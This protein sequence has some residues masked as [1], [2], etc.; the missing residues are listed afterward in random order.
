[1]A[2]P[3]SSADRE[4]SVADQF[5]PCPRFREVYQNKQ[6]THEEARIISSVRHLCPHA[7]YL[8]AFAPVRE[9]HYLRKA[10]LEYSNDSPEL[11][12]KGWQCRLMPKTSIGPSVKVCFCSPDGGVHTSKVTVLRKLGIIDKGVVFRN[13]VGDD[14]V[15]SRQPR[16]RKAPSENI[17]YVRPEKRN[18]ELIAIVDSPFGLLEELFHDNPWRL[19]LST[20]LLNRTT[21]VQVDVVLFEF[22]TKWP[23]PESVV[24]AKWEDI[25]SVIRPLGIRHRRAKGL[26]RFSRDYLELL[27]RKD[28]TRWSREDV[29][30]LYH[31]GDYAYDAYRIFMQ[32]NIATLATD[33]A[34]QDYVEYQRGA[35]ASVDTGG[36]VYIQALS[37]LRNC[38]M[39]RK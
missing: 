39:N 20:I 34:L 18:F 11:F 14:L 36:L 25:S 24:D 1:M 6:S 19:L 16:K 37:P 5:L 32:K 28:P 26:I 10:I 15:T 23:K 3:P 21:R 13:R 8:R 17:N 31:C 30:S 2:P 9:W 7:C 27:Q 38:A 12:L 4:Q 29:L 33:H 35:L 22:L